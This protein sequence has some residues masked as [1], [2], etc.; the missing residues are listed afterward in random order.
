MQK[1]PKIFYD[2]RNFGDDGDVMLVRIEERNNNNGAISQCIMMK[3]NEVD[4]I[5]ET[6]DAYKRR[7]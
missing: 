3:K 2:M 5:M 1:Q 4:Q 7:N 6:I